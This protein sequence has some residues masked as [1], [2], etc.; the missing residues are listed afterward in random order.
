MAGFFITLFALVL[1]GC[2]GNIRRAWEVFVNPAL[3]VIC[4]CIVMFFLMAFRDTDL[5]RLIKDKDNFF[6][7]P[8]LFLLPLILFFLAAIFVLVAALIN[9]FTRGYY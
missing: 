4:F 6:L 9:L 8:L 1:T 5:K 2:G 3:I 7:Q